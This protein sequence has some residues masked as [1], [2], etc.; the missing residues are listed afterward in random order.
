MEKMRKIKTKIEKLRVEINHHNHLY[1]VL[2]SPEISDTEYD[3]LMRQ[4][5]QLEEEYVQF[6][7]SDSPT[8][9]I[10]AAP[11]EAF[12]IVEHPQP[13]LSLR[14]AFSE[15]EI[16]AWYKRILKLMNDKEFDF[17]CE[18]K[19]D[20]LAVALTYE[21]S[22]LTVGATRGDGFHG[23]NITRNLRTIRSIP[24]S[25]TKEAP[26]RFEV[27]G[28]VFLPR[29]GFKKLNRERSKDDLP[30]FANPRNA[31][32]G[33]LRQLDPRITATR[34]LDIYIYML[35]YTE[36]STIPLSHWE[37]LKYIKSL[38]FKVNPNNSKLGNIDQVKEYYNT[39]LEGREGL[40]YEAD[41]VVVKINQIDMQER[42]G[43]IGHEP[44]WA[45]AYKFPAVQGTTLLKEIK[46]SVG[47]TGTMNPF[48]VLEPVSLGGVTIKQAALHNEDDIRRKDVREGDTVIIQRAGDVIPQVI[49]PVKG[50]RPKITKEFNLMQKTEGKCPQCKFD[51]FKPEGEI[52][53]YCPNVACPAQRQQR[54]GHFASRGA[55]DIKGIGDKM[56]A[57]LLKGGLVNDF[58]DLYY[59]KNKLGEITSIEGM[60]NKSV[61]NML[62]A[63]EKSKNRPLSRFLYSL[64]IRHVG[65]E[66]ADLL[67]KYFQRIKRLEDASKEEL[68][69][70]ET[71]GPKIADSVVSFFENEENKCI[72]KK[73][74]A[75]G[76]I[77]EPVEAKAE[78]LTLAGKEFVITGRL[79]NFS[80]Q[81]AEARIR[82]IG[83]SVKSDVTQKT[84]FVV[85]GTE[86]GSKLIR[87]NE[88]GIEQLNEGDLMRLLD[89]KI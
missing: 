14:N 3:K 4:L 10:G 60:A 42:L 34:P 1:H 83:G 16:I 38:G 54:I 86:P 64:G 50:K 44:R 37:M 6:L 68:M 8:Q 72:L 81:E 43:N 26:R 40:P 9:R 88:L 18:H 61:D 20:G 59:L 22:R 69:D 66:T 21:N 33:S 7:T 58:A 32:A 82:A 5:K 51:I 48:A 55:M 71:I 36:S 17:V 24:L 57:M 46:I 63:I 19:I 53:Y 28:E 89:Y 75:A 29:E 73:L 70:I 41:G 79:D 74:E 35:G 52:M 45:I 27:R 13:L 39:W 85:V 76:V 11:V 25:V 2:D 67:A 56:S 12:G 77:Q 78:K 31:A 84:D 87:A 80:R 47:R 15:T 62:A 65:G 23:E 30:L 49:G